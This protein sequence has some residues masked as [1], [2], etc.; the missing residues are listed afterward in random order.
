MDDIVTVHNKA[1]CNL[2]EWKVLYASLKN[3]LRNCTE[4]EFEECIQIALNHENVKD[5]SK[6][7]EEFILIRNENG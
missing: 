7:R 1:Q 5:E 2:K 4:E 3:I 6:L